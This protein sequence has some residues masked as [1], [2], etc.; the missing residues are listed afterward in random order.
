MNIH[1]SFSDIKEY[2]S[3][4]IVAEVNNEYV[5]LAKIKGQE[6]PWHAH[7]NEDEMFYIVSGRLLM[8]LEDKD[9]FIMETGDLFVVKKG[10]THRVSSTE[11]CMIMLIE[12][13]T[14]KHTG[15]V[16]S[17]ITKS[18]DQQSY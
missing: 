13:K 16:V 3:P 17:T 15:D 9:P 5:K 6:V 11:E 14:T 18:I 8:E 2:F 4:K 10:T 12:T 1:A 7:E